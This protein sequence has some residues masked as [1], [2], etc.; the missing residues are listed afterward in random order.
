MLKPRLIVLASMIAAAA[1][2]RLIP[3]PPN[4]TSVAAVGLFAGATFSDRRMAFAIPL[5]ALLLSDVVL[6]FYRHMEVVYVAFALI[7]CIGMAIKRQRTPIIIAGATLTGS[8]LFFVVTNF[9]VWMFD[10]YYPRTPQGLA[11]C[12]VAAM[13]FFAHTLEGDFFYVALLF[14]VFA[15]LERRFFVLSEPPGRPA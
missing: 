2:S 15:L 9:G 14:G 3:H 7:V 10:S 5:A 1:A 4:F 8:M 13:P 11:E 12:Y 6:G